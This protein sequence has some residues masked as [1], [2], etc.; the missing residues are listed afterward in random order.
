MSV[1]LGTI[2]VLIFPDPDQLGVRAIAFDQRLHLQLGPVH[3][4]FAI[5]QKKIGRHRRFQVG[6]R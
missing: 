6:H 2:Y 4:Y 1:L 3:E 5:D